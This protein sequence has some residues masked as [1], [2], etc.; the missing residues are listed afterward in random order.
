MIHH[1]IV[2]HGRS[3][4][5][6]SCIPI[7]LQFGGHAESVKSYTWVFSLM[8]ICLP[9]REPISTL[10]CSLLSGFLMI[11][12]SISSSCLLSTCL[13]FLLPAFVPSHTKICF[14]STVCMHSLTSMDSVIYY[15]RSGNEAQCTFS[16]VQVR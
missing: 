4:Q 10:S 6:S 11:Y 7:K 1:N 14:T 15:I 8:C 3:K 12:I 2:R 16:F 5:E 13:S 9:P